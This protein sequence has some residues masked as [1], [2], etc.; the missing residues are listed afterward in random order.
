MSKDTWTV[1]TPVE[2]KDGKTFW[3]RI[4]AAWK[5]DDGGFSVVLDSLPINGKILIAPPREQQERGSVPKPGNRT[6]Q[7]DDVPF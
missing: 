7:D 2:R 4:G 5:R 3:A 6:R 1:S